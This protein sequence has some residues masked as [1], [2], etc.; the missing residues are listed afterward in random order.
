MGR[1]WSWAA[2]AAMLPVMAIS[3]A[4]PAFADGV[5]RPKQRRH[6]AA[7]PAERA[8]YAPRGRGIAAEMRID[9]Y[10]YTYEPRGY[11]PYYNAGYWKPNCGA[12]CKPYY[13]QPPYWQA[14]GYCGPYWE[15]LAE[16]P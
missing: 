11:Y 5:E 13:E 9:P 2:A 4:A 10:L 6:Y 1:A 7:A 12:V 15:Q 3:A 16:P 8:P 14:W